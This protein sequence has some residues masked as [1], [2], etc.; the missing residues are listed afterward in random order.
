MG[1]AQVILLDTHVVVWP[2]FDQKQISTRARAAIAEARTKADGLS[3]CD[4]SLLEFATLASKGRIRLDV[5]LESFLDE[6]ESGLV[7]LPIHGRAC[8]PWDFPQAMPKIQP[9]AGSERRRWPGVYRCL[10]LTVRFGAQERCR[11]SGERDA[12]E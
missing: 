8:A 9:I 7:V 12:A 11:R 4:I 6:V 3:I 5:T 2:A 10:R 1:R